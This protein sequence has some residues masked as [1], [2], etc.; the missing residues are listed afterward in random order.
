MNFSMAIVETIQCFFFGI[1]DMLY[2]PVSCVAEKLDKP[3]FEFNLRF[4]FTATTSCS[5]GEVQI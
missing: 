3:F 4:S 5:E 2:A 1:C